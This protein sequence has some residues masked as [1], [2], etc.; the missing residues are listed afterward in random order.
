[1]AAGNGRG[2]EF[3]RY[4][5]P[6]P[7]EST[8][9]IAKHFFDVSLEVTGALT[10][11]LSSMDVVELGALT[12]GDSS[13]NTEITAS[14][15]GQDVYVITVPLHGSYTIRQGRAEIRHPTER[16][17]V[18]CEPED[19]IRLADWVNDCRSLT[20]TIDRQAVHRQL[21][22]L[23]GRP[24]P[25]RLRFP[26]YI[27]V[28]QGPGRSWMNLARWSLMEKEISHGLLQQPIIAGRLEQTLL[29]GLL[30]AA[31]HQYR[32]ALES[33]PLTMRPA[34]VKRVMDAVR[35]RP[36]EPYDAARLAEIAQV[37]LRTL[38]EAFR[39]NIGMSPM[40]Y[41]NEVR[42]KRVREELRVATPGT[43]TVTEVALL[44]GFAHLGRFAQR[45]RARFGES[46]SQTLRAV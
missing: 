43:V 19:R 37:S 44:W 41:V 16:Q 35:E 9:A 33:P 31:D 24:V 23:L 7:E 11:F 21:E 42:L 29:E 12:V 34:A 40:A 27:D 15:A 17:A 8:A 3:S 38:Q 25:H 18:L 39:T 20:V 30:L 1:M 22:T 28:S 2:A 14:W 36:A 4:V 45:Y 6:D 13:F 32:D 26:P 46:P 5:T 10:D